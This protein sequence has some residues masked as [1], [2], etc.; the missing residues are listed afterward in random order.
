MAQSAHYERLAWQ[1]T[2]QGIGQELRQRYAVPQ[3]LPH[4]LAT[5]LGEFDKVEAG[6][7]RR[8]VSKQTAQDVPQA[9]SA[10]WLKKLDALEGEGLLR[11]C[12][13]RLKER[14]R[15]D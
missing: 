9:A 3:D 4:R 15:R 6:E 8:H 2:R 14:R 11:A 10:G 13:E 1:L 5:L 7:R 12:R